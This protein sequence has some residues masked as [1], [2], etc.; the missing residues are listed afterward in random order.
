MEHIGF[1]V[2]CSLRQVSLSAI[3]GATNLVSC[4]FKSSQCNSVYNPQSNCRAWW[5]HQ[6]ETSSA[7]LALCAGNSPATGEFPLQRPVTRRFDVFYDLRLNKRLNKHSRRWWF[8]MPSRP[9]WRHCNGLDYMA[10][11]QRCSP[12]NGHQM[13][14][15]TSHRFCSSGNWPFPN[16]LLGSAMHSK[17]LCPIKYSL[18]ILPLRIVGFF[19]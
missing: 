15:P 18:V 3:T 8:D 17:W 11:Y 14:C 7:L 2:S 13:T 6:M 19:L 1:W 12:G 4:H 10:G 5:R 9:L 16:Q